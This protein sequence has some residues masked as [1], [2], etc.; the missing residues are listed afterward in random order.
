MNRYVIH[1]KMSGGI[2]VSADLIYTTE[3]INK[4]D[5]SGY[6]KMSG[7]KGYKEFINT[8]RRTIKD[9]KSVKVK[10]VYGRLNPV[11]DYMD[12]LIPVEIYDESEEPEVL[13]TLGFGFSDHFITSEDGI[14]SIDYD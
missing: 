10:N 6:F 2:P 4:I 13:D 1:Y 3:K 14:F 5:I 12:V 7:N 8:F 11:E 9:Y